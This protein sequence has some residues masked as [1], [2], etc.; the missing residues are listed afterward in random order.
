[1]V[2]ILLSRYNFSEEYKYEDQVILLQLALV[3]WLFQSDSHKLS[4]HMPRLA[5][6]WDI[7]GD[8]KRGLLAECLFWLQPNHLINS[9]TI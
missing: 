3:W 6:C 7:V 8:R 4:I 9:Q 5:L 2:M 1:M